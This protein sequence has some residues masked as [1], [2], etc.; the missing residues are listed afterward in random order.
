MRMTRTVLLSLGL[1]TATLVGCS[2]LPLQDNTLANYRRELAKLV[3]AGVLTKDDE[4]K[5][6]RIAGLEVERRAKQHYQPSDPP[7]LPTGFVPLP[8]KAREL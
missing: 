4:E 6:Y 7:A 8:R 5:F 2:G 3:E 1:L